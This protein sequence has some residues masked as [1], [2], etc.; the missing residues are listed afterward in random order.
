MPFDAL[1]GSVVSD[2]VKLRLARDGISENWRAHKLGLKDADSHCLVGWLLAVTD[3]NEEETARLALDYV[4]PALPK[5]AQQASA[6][7]SLVDYNDNRSHRRV[8]RLL[9]RAIERAETIAA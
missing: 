3:W 9:D 8:V 1:S 5:S 7:D 6:I 2:V 4:F